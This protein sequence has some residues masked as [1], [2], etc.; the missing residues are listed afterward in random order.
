MCRVTGDGR[1]GRSGVAPLLLIALLVT[2]CAAPAPSP[3]PLSTTSPTS[4]PPI[5]TFTPIPGPLVVTLTLW[6]PEDISPYSDHPGADLLT[7][8][9]A[10]FGEAHPDLQIQVIVKKNQGR[11][12]LLDFL[13]T[14]S[15]VAPSVL[16]DLIVLEQTDLQV[17]AQA[18][19][20][21]AM[22]G[23]VSADWLS[24]FFPFATE[25]GRIGD[26]TFGLPLTAELEHLA[27]SP[28]SLQTPPLSWQEVISAPVPL[29]FPAAGQNDNADH[30]T[31]IQ[32]L[33][34]GGRIADE[35]G[36]PVLDEEPL[37]A[38]LDFYAQASSTG[39][40]S[41]LLVL[42]LNDTE[43]CWARF[44]AEGG[45]AVVDSRR[46]WTEGDREAEPAP[47]PTRDGRPMAL[48]RG[49]TIALVTTNPERQQ[50]AM[51]LAAWLLDPAWYG[52]WTQSTGYLPVTRSGLAAWGISGTQ[53]ET[54][55]AILEGARAAPPPAL[56]NRVGPPIRAAVEAVLRGRMSP[57][58]AATQTAQS[59]R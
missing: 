37:T 16:P 20:I 41:P 21:Q 11:G 49:W 27:Y 40:I 19:L 43:G 8:R 31:L 29:L 53:R 44:Q 34:A 47:I 12:G 55:T 45:M 9:L 2:A 46:F 15:A 13:R 35:K 59:V 48:A 24:D 30:F 4:P 38:V 56:R 10:E 58:E 17:A 57:R 22:E 28:A 52:G 51:A 33:S 32:Y 7:Q 3:S 23:L 39:V 1:E 5:P 50:R 6:V 18:G 14:A 42:S 25:L 54:L 36:N 26:R